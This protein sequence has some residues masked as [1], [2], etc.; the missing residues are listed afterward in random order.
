MDQAQKPTAGLLTILAVLGRLLP[1]PPNFTPLTGAT[2]FGGAKLAK[3]WN[4]LL[5]I[6][7]LFLTDIFLGFHKTMPYVYVSFLAIAV[8]GQ[9]FLKKKASL[10][11]VAG[12]SLASSLLFFLV[13]N[14]G[15]WQVGG[16]YP[17]TGAGLMES[18]LMGLPFLRNT[19]AGDVVFSVGFFALYQ[20]AEGA[21]W[22]RKIDRQ[23]INII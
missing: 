19:V 21:E 5:P 4:Y 18:Y 13:T 7:V 6:A 11:R 1:H 15:V 3:P 17:H 9:L 2:L 12:L 14:F 16:L 8:F 10:W 20:W 22:V 23:I